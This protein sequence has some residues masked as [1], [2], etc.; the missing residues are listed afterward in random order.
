L[1]FLFKIFQ[2]TAQFSIISARKLKVL[3]I[4]QVREQQK[5]AAAIL[6]DKIA[7][8]SNSQQ[9]LPQQLSS[10]P[11]QAILVQQA[12]TYAAEP[13]PCISGSPSTISI[14]IYQAP[15]QQFVPQPGG[16][17]MGMLTT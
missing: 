3:S 10:S 1:S 2:S 4:G 7:A 13:S 9:I 16:V 12:S 15:P 17:M 11:R 8:S 5:T 6:A 14:S